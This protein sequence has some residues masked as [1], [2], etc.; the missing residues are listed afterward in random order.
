MLPA[1]LAIQLDKANAEKRT[2]V[3]E[4]NAADTIEKDAAQPVTQ[5]QDMPPKEAEAA[6]ELQ[7]S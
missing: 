4:I 1:Q 6:V 7:A 5:Y 3:Q 2:E